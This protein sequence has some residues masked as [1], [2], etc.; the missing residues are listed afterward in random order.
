[1]G[2]RGTIV[3]CDDEELIRWSLNEHLTAEGY[4]VV[5]AEDGQDCLEKVEAH[6]P[7]LIL[8]DLKMPRM[9]GMEML[10]QLR[11]SDIETPV[12]VLTAHS[13]VDSAVEATR[14]GARDYLSKPFDLREIS[15]T[16]EKVLQQERL[17]NEVRYLRGQQT[18][19]YNRIIGQSNPMQRL[20]HTL[21][22]LERVDAPTVLVVGESGTGKDLIAHAIHEMGPRRSGPMMEVDCASLPEQLIESELFGHERGAFTDA[23]QAKRGLFEVARGGTIFLDEIGEMSP[24]TQAK[25]LRALE[26]RRFKRVGGVTY[27]DL[28]AS[29]IAATNRD[30]SEEVKKGRFREDLFFRLNV[31]RIEVPALRSRREDIP[32]LVDHLV[33]KF[34]RDF[35]R[36]I[37]GIS[38][39]ALQ[40]MQAY[41][42][43]G[44]VRELRNVIERVIILEADEIIEADHLPAEI[45]YGGSRPG[46]VGGTFVLPEEGVN[47]EEVERSLLQQA[48]D[49][50]NANQSAAARLLGISR[51]ALR[52]RLEKYGLM[53]K[54]SDAHA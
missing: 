20:F 53:G 15:L 42:W 39:A 43:P 6:A 22:R 35:R 4:R 47:L 2:E 40:L 1:M 30:L 34:N 21:R 29:V 19:A 5:E 33:E 52:Y 13:A 3:V 46:V 16:V 50:T 8:S 32:L 10:R 48:M 41:T 54:P 12:I 23:R 17:R 24:S 51:Y 26:N 28:D 38:E 44:N 25:L 7:D 36:N 9:G 45:R 18:G 14:L 37:R 27:M 31:I 49:R 11:A